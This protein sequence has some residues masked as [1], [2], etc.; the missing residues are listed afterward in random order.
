MSKFPQ[1]DN[2]KIMIAASVRHCRRTLEELP[3]GQI[4]VE[5][6]GVIR[7]IDNSTIQFF[8]LETPVGKRLCELLGEPAKFPKKLSPAH[9]GDLGDWVFLSSNGTSRGRIVCVPGVHHQ[10]FLLTIVFASE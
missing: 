2:A 4:I 8:G 6:N 7:S 3:V 9:Y 10:T 5:E 1:Y